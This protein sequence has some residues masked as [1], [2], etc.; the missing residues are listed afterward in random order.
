MEKNN[1]LTVVDGKDLALKKAN[2]L[3]SI[4][5]KI[6]ESN[7]MSVVEN[8]N[9]LDELIAW[10]NENEVPT[11]RFP[12]D[13]NKIK[14]LT[15]LILAGE[16]P[17]YIPHHID[18]HTNLTK[19]NSSNYGTLNLF[20]SPLFNLPKNI[21]NLGKLKTLDLLNTQFTKLP[22]SIGDL[23]NL[24]KLVIF[25]NKIINLPESIGNLSNLSDLTMACNQ[26]V[27]LPDSIGNLRKLKE[28]DL[29]C[30][31]LV[32]LPKSMSKLS[33]LVL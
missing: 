5:S 1:H 9:W 32:R 26:I 8:E 30:R 24:V 19:L 21:G 17:E 7:T 28:I 16:M 11:D 25:D 33:N 27:A 13:K 31:Q 22:D 14:N 20:K 2:R 6:L 15:E 18:I 3:L 4:T 12:R 10:A 29:M 23:S